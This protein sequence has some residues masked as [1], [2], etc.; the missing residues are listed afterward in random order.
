V[1]VA[2]PLAATERSQW[3]RFGL[4]KLAAAYFLALKLAYIFTAFPIADE[5]YYWLW[6]R[7]PGLSYFDH[8]GLQAW[9]QGLSHLAFGTNLFALRL[10]TLLALAGCLWVIAAVARQLAGAEWQRLFWTGAVIF[11]ASPMFGLFGSLAFHD[12]LLVFLC[13]ASG[14]FFLSYFVAYEREGGGRHRDLV[15]AAALLG[16][17]GLTKYN[18]VFLGLGVLATILIR[19]RLRPMLA[20]WPIWAAAGLALVLQAPTVIWNIS[21]NFASLKF[22]LVDRHSPDWL[23]RLRLGHLRVGIIEAL[24]FAS[25]LLALMMARLFLKRARPGLESL[26]KTLAICTFWMSSTVFLAISAFDMVLGWWNVVGLVMALPFLARHAGRIV[27]ALH[28]AYGVVVGTVLTAAFTLLPFTLLVGGTPLPETEAAYDWPKVAAAVEAARERYRPDFIAASSYQRASQLAFALDD[29]EVTEI[30]PRRD[31]FDF[32]FDPAAHEGQS[33]IVLV[34]ANR[35]VDYVAARF[36]R[37]E[38]V[39]Q[40]V[41][42][43]FGHVLKRLDI[44]HGQGYREPDAVSP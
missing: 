44:Y 17:A 28:V 19:P 14:F 7:R 42:E 37:V 43:R 34:E 2:V 18:A 39:E 20:R 12:Y 25:P 38:L 23:S 13:L 26:G 24:A 40:V 22:H 3:R 1:T 36:E 31:Q 6:G 4:L 29:P 9:V 10:P 27:M 30:A 8:P 11:L 35:G 32:W 21:E 41:M 33:A 5:A 15:L 16:L